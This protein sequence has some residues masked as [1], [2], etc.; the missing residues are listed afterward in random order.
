[1][2]ISVKKGIKD[3]VMKK[4]MKNENEEREEIIQ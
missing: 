2:K 3:K 4:N 1:L